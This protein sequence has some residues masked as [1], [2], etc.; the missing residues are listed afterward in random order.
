MTEKT[1]EERHSIL[2]TAWSM[3]ASFFGV[4]SRKNFEED[5]QKGRARDFIIVGIVLVIL[6]HLGIYGIVQ[7]VLSQV[8]PQ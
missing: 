5:V 2:R 6:I 4:Q 7:L 8:P 1:S 3:L